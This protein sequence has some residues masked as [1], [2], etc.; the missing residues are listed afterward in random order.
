[1]DRRRTEHVLGALRQIVA[2]RNGLLHEL[3]HQQSMVVQE[4]VLCQ[5]FMMLGS[6]GV[7]SR[8][9]PELMMAIKFGREYLKSLVIPPAKKYVMWLTLQNDVFYRGGRAASE[10]LSAARIG[11]KVCC[12]ALLVVVYL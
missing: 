5:K 2:L 4:E 3:E 6:H 11:E 10:R 7:L 8:T 12:V 9:S 1:M